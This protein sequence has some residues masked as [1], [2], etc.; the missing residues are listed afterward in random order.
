MPL[1]SGSLIDLALVPLCLVALALNVAAETAL[2]NISRLRL[3]QLLDRGVP[4]AQLLSQIL[5]R[6]RLNTILRSADLVV[7]VALAGLVMDL[8]G[9]LTRRDLAADI[10]ALALTARSR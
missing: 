9:S 8:A 5:D 6:P 3:R 4:R 7:I 10:G 2:S 1:D